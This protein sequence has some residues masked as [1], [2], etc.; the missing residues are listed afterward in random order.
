MLTTAKQM[1]GW[2]FQE[3]GIQIYT[4]RKRLLL[5][6]EQKWLLKLVL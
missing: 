4:K 1:E 3:H 6:A 2:I 5:T